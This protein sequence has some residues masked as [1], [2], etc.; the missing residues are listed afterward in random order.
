MTFLSIF[1]NE[2]LPPFPIGVGV[3][4]S[5]DNS[6]SEWRETVPKEDISSSLSP[7]LRPGTLIYLFFALDFEAAFF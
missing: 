1:A 7:P 5:A 3:A 6:S 2:K 4:S